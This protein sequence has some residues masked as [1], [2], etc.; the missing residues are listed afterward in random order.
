MGGGRSKSFEA[1]LQGEAQRVLDLAA[2]NF[3]VAREAGKDGKSGS[4]G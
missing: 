1:I 2:G 3:V 4:I